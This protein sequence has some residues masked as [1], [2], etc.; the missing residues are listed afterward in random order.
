[1]TREVR[2][3]PPTKVPFRARLS[4]ID[5]KYSP[6]AYI[7]PFFLVFAVVGLFPIIYT[8]YISTRKWNSIAGDLGVAV[9]YGQAG[10]T[11]WWGNFAWVF[12][13]HDF[14]RALLNTFSIFV[15]S[16]GPQIILAII[17]ATVLS[18]NLRAKTFWRMGV[19]LPY[20]VAPMAAGIIFRQMFADETGVVNT[21]LQA[22]GLDP[23]MWHGNTLASHVA[24]ACIINF[25]WTGY[26]TLVL[27]AAMQAIPQEVIEAAVVDG[28]GR[29]RQLLSVILPMIRPTLMFVIITSTI[30]GLQVFDE[31]QLYSISQSYGGSNNQFLTVTQFLWKTGFTSNNDSN[32]GRAA[33][34]AWIL[35]VI[36]VIFAVLS[37]V[38]TSR[39]A[40]TGTAPDAKPKTR[41]KAV[42]Q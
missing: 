6:Y 12:A 14:R 41:K 29:V 33:A 15:L 19:L 27:L 1:M 7:S 32:M 22:I 28:A 8:A 26:N 5:V 25:R 2:L 11:S 4:R 34:V 42:S 18:A 20:V 24:I 16:S 10:Q 9:A 37:Y 35:F 13:N 39:I 17:L 31:P 40:S 36:V 30:G 23:V 21:V 3:Q 38:L